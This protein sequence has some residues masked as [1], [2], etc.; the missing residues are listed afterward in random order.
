MSVRTRT[1]ITKQKSILKQSEKFE[2]WTAYQHRN[3]GG[4]CAPEGLGGL[5]TSYRDQMP[6]SSGTLVRRTLWVVRS[7]VSLIIKSSSIINSVISV[8]LDPPRPLLSV[9]ECP[10]HRDSE[11][12]ICPPCLM[13][14]R[15][16]AQTEGVLLSFSS[17]S[18][19]ASSSQLLRRPCA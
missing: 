4:A 16:R 2:S 5:T 1:V 17:S 11:R 13:K 15:H 12:Y 18:S 6:D 3:P 14:K 10:E 7:A 8:K 19:S 9:G